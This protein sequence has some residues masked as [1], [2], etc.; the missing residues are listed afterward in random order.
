MKRESSAPTYH[1]SV[2]SGNP[3]PLT[4]RLLLPLDFEKCHSPV[5]AWGGHH[6]VP[7][8][9]VWNSLLFTLLIVH[10]VHNFFFPLYMVKKE[11]QCLLLASVQCLII[12]MWKG[13]GWCK[14]AMESSQNPLNDLYDCSFFPRVQLLTLKQLVLNNFSRYGLHITI[15]TVTL[16]NSQQAE[17]V[18][19]VPNIYFI[20]PLPFLCVCKW[21]WQWEGDF[22]SSGA[23]VLSVW[24][25]P[26]REANLNSGPLTQNKLS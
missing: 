2:F 11:G 22:T 13:R 18:R 25:W 9:A 15:I 17:A 21:T 19:T 14:A 16:N 24:T 4:L 7:H 1:V 20:S 3:P 6:W 23:A 8:T 5:M 12:S 26:A 10:R